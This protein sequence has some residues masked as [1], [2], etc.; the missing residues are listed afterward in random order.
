MPSVGRSWRIS[1]LEDSRGR[2]SAL[3]NTVHI[4]VGDYKTKLKEGMII[5]LEVILKLW[6][7]KLHRDNSNPRD[8]NGSRVYQLMLQYMQL[9]PCTKYTQPAFVASLKDRKG[10]RKAE[11]NATD[12]SPTKKGSS[13]AVLNDED[14]LEYTMIK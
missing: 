1:D 4:H 5:E 6:T 9:L 3:L 13:S 8:V 7:I 11:D 10:K 2:Y 12:Q 14:E